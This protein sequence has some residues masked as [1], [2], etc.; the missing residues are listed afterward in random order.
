MESDEKNLNVLKQK[1]DMEKK[2]VNTLENELENYLNCKND[3][4][5][6]T[7]K[8][9]NKNHFSIICKNVET[10]SRNVN[11]ILVNERK[12][13]NE[14][15]INN[16]LGEN[17][18]KIIPRLTSTINHS[19][20]I[21]K[22]K[23]NADEK[24]TEKEIKK[25]RANVQRYRSVP[26]PKMRISKK[27]KYKQVDWKFD[28]FFDFENHCAKGSHGIKNGGKT[29]HCNE[30]YCCCFYRI[31]TPMIANTGI[32]KIKLKI[33]KIGENWWNLVGMT[34]STYKTNNPDPQEQCW[35]YSSDCIGWTAKS[36]ANNRKCVNGIFCGAREDYV[37]ENIFVR[38]KFKYVSNNDANKDC[39]PRIKNKD[40]IIL[41]YDSNLNI[42]HLAKE[43]DSSF[44]ARLVHLPKYRTLYWFVGHYVRPLSMTIM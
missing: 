14:I 23:D 7:N 22:T 21:T 16:K 2:Q 26:I 8:N 19:F 18:N 13:I 37:Q 44:D 43:T 11:K 9:V 27:S 24:E 3:N 30:E 42:L 28:Y 20:K 4:K 10:V 1:I 31:N 34:S 35:F 5:N 6:N 41:T 36:Y 33:D 40:V 38:N 32:Y 25:E 12:G 39:I 17:V 29:I 15:T